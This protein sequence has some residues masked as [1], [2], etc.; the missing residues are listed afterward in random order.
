MTVQPCAARRRRL[1]LRHGALHRG[2]RGLR[3]EDLPRRLARRQPR[4][5]GPAQRRQAHPRLRPRHDRRPRSV[6]D[7]QPRD[8]DLLHHRDRPAGL[9]R[10][11][12]LGAAAPT[13]CYWSSKG[14]TK[15]NVWESK[16]LVTWSDLRQFDV[17]L[18]ATARSVAELGMA[19][20][21]EATWVDDYYADGRGA[22]VVYWSSNVYPN[23][24]HTGSSYTRILWGATTDF[25]QEHLRVRRRLHRRR[26][27]HHRHHD[28]PERRQDL[29]HH[30]GQL[31]GQGHL[32]GVDDRAAEWWKP[33]ATWTQLQTRIGAVWAGRQR[34][35]RRGPRGLQAP[36]R[37][38]AGTSTSTSSP[39]TGYRPMQTDRPRRRLVAAR[40]Q[41]LLHGAEHEARRHRL[42]DE[43]A[44]RHDPR[45]GRRRRRH[46]RPRLASRSPGRCDRGRGRARRCRQSAEVVLAYGRG[47]ATQ[48]VDVGPVGRRRSA[49]PGTYDV[50]GTVRTIG[51]N[52]NQWVGAGGSTAWNAPDRKLYSSTAI[53]VTA[54]RRRRS[55]GRCPSRSPPTRAASPARSC[56]RSSATERRRRAG[57]PRP[58]APPYGSKTIAALSPGKSTSAAFTTRSASIAAGTV[59]VAVSAGQAQAEASASYGA[60]SCG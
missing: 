57:R 35:R 49:T 1:R 28:H 50:T 23:A 14:S 33:A 6:P 54:E 4:A 38:P 9:R 43:G 56:S 41:R 26:R 32:H 17:A 18:V 19:W 45:S 30:E 39:S 20:A 13:W 36:R 2:L 7:L 27:Q 10:R 5:V 15:L 42:A 31:G 22:F 21:P 40:E 51:A 44:V 46:E 12:R 53:T 48:P 34:R 3:R 24:A 58:S 59:S 8:R 25:T 47:T 52:L 55:A 29:P 37:R 60:A 16:D 11:P